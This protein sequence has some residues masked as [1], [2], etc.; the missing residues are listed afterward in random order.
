MRQIRGNPG[1]TLSKAEQTPGADAEVMDSIRRI[2][3]RGNNAEVKQKDGR[4]VVYEV[5]KRIAAG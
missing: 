1:Q 2:T 4:L 5:R 3:G